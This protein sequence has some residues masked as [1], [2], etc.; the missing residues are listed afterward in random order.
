MMGKKQGQPREAIE[1]RVRSRWIHGDARDMLPGTTY[2][3]TDY[4][5]KT[6]RNE[7]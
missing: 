2:A 7:V 4:S 6:K 3:Q 5:E 1:R